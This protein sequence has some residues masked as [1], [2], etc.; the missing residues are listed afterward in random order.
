MRR[1]ADRPSRWWPAVKTLVGRPTLS[2]RSLT[3][4]AGAAMMPGSMGIDPRIYLGP[5]VQCR[6]RSA[7]KTVSK[8]GCPKDACP[9]AA[10]RLI[11]YGPP[12]TEPRFCQY[13]GSR[14]GSVPVT[15]PDRPSPYAVVGDALFRLTGE[16]E[17]DDA[18]L[19]LGANL[20]GPRPFGIDADEPFHVDLSDEAIGIQREI[21]EMKATYAAEI[22]KLRAVCDDV[23]VKWGLHQY[24]S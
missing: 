1:D 12:P 5:Y 14:F 24:F 22:E 19:Y 11:P 3:F 21:A 6:Y 18:M 15:V 17:P 9:G 13:C 8:F 10:Q 7:T 2:T 4:R 16:G 20:P 23:S